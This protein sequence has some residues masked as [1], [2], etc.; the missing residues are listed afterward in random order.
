M[1]KPML[2]DETPNAGRI[3]EPLTV[4]LQL[5]KEIHGYT[6]ELNEMLLNN[7]NEDILGSK[8]EERGLIIN[9]IASLKKDYDS[10][11]ECVNYADNKEKAH[12]DKLRQEIQH[13]GNAIGILDAENVALI[14]NYIKDIT[15]NLEKIQE[16]KHLVSDLKKHMSNSP[17]FVDVCG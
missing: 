13:I 6:R 16:G 3:I 8:F 1:N 14:K 10:V 2:S 12:R 7:C 17:V 11:K 15:F 4:Q 5:Y 9:T